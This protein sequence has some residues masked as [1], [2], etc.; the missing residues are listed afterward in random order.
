MRLP[1]KV[2]DK[3]DKVI[4]EP[5]RNANYLAIFAC[6]LASIAIIVVMVRR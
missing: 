5:I 2:K 3:V 1:V 6:I 4:A